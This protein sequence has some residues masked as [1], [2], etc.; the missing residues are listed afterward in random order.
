MGEASETG[1]MVL[2]FKGGKGKFFSY[3]WV[4]ATL[5]PLLSK[6]AN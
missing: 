3:E 4:N 5:S 2:V 6:W 1:D